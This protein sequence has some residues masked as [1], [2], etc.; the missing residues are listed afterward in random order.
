MDLYQIQIPLADNDGK[1]YDHFPFR[2]HLLT[3][4]GGYTLFGA[5]GAWRGDDG[6][7]HFDSQTIYQVATDDIEAVEAVV[8]RLP[9]WFPGQEA[10]FWARIGEAWIS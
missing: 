10:W 8:L 5:A 6:H 9:V 4:F 3:T 2:D 7:T 1:P